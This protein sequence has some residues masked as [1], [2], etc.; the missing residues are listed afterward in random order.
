MPSGINSVD[1]E[2]PPVS[3]NESIKWFIPDS[4]LS[5]DS[6][7]T[8]ILRTCYA[9]L[10]V[11]VRLP[12]L[13]QIDSAQSPATLSLILNFFSL[14]YLVKHAAAKC[15]NHLLI[16]AEGDSLSLQRLQRRGTA[17]L[18]QLERRVSRD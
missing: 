11:Q 8:R 4:E 9:M 3:L 7:T 2:D 13:H 15:E 16:L 18:L 5:R 1:R 6:N 12:V 10:Q 17:I 14:V